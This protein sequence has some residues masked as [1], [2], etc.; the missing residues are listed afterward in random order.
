MDS[1]IEDC[2]M[3]PPKVLLKPLPHALIYTYLDVK[4]KCPVIANDTLDDSSLEK[5]L[6][7]L[8]KYKGVI[9]YSIDDIKGISPSLDMH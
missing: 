4:H 2:T 5:L 9:G 7:L 8:R 6:V 1:A 3:P